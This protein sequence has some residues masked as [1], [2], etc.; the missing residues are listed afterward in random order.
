[1]KK[2]AAILASAALSCEAAAYKEYPNITGYDTFFGSYTRMP[3]AETQLAKAPQ[4]EGGREP[5]LISVSRWTAGLARERYDNKFAYVGMFFAQSRSGEQTYISN[6]TAKLKDQYG[7]LYGTGLHLNQYV[8][9]SL[10]VEISSGK[11]II[12]DQ[13][14]SDLGVGL[15]SEVTL[16][17]NRYFQVGGSLLISRHYNGFGLTLRGRY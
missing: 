4:R 10:F 16:T 13:A 2:I 5:A 9:W 12:D 11:I 3:A 17:P 14:Y 15:G 7:F 1:M 6:H 8:D